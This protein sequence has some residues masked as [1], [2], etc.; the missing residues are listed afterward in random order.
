MM[1]KPKNALIFIVED[2]KAY[3]KLIEH[4]LKSNHY[5]NTMSFTSGEDCLKKIYLKPSIIIQDFVLMGINGLNVLEKTKKILPDT[6]FIFL[7][8]KNNVDFAVNTLK[9][10]AS[11]YIVKD[12][13][14]LQKLLQK[15]E[16][17]IQSQDLKKRHKI[18]NKISFLIFFSIMSL[19]VIYFAI[20]H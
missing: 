2:N 20:R 7:S 12:E 9:S 6:D 15:V 1:N 11:D 14:S 19:I 13:N 17:I 18:L 3:N 4:H 5:E 10:G 8:I 16:N